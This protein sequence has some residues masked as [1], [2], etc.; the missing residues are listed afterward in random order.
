[1]MKTRAFSHRLRTAAI[2]SGLLLVSTGCNSVDPDPFSIHGSWVGGVTELE[3]VLTMV[4]IGQGENGIIG[5]AEMTSPTA[6]TVQGSVS[7]TRDR[8]DV[9]LTIEID[10]AIVGGS[11]V[12]DGAF[13]GEDTM[14]GTLDSGI[15]G[16]S[17]PITFQRE[18]V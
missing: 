18:Q 13:G 1:M 9:N 8:N 10:D 7:G 6:G 12:F 3:V 15:L 17:W 11:L 2:T 5:S 16:G 4:L 14:T